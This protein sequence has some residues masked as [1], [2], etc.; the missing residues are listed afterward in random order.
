MK[1]LF[2]AIA[3]CL[4]LHGYSQPFTL[5][6]DIN[7]T[8][9]TSSST[10]QNMTVVGSTLYF[11]ATDPFH[12]QELWKTDGTAAGTVMVKDIMVGTGSSS[13]QN[14]TDFGGTL[15]FQANNGVN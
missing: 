11:V 8:L 6:K 4:S 3:L 5:L 15:Y 7:T 10:P 13:P 12:G 9:S 2:G 14:L 1:Y